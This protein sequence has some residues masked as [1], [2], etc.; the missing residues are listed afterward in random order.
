MEDVRESR[1]ILNLV[2][3]H[4]DEA[5]KKQI[6]HW[7]EFLEQNRELDKDLQQSLAQFGKA[8]NNNDKDAQKVKELPL[9]ID[10]RNQVDFSLTERRAVSAYHQAAPRERWGKETGAW[11]AIN[12]TARAAEQTRYD[13]KKLAQTINSRVPETVGN[14]ERET[15]KRKQR[16]IV[17]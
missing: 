2:Y 13:H 8:L 14:A 5:H 16:P 17:S 12:T 3:Q 11:K 7:D 4:I 1:R 6:K 10:C 9:L 15:R